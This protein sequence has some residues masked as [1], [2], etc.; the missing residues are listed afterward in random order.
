MQVIMKVIIHAIMK[1][2]MH[3]IMPVIMDLIKQVIQ[4]TISMIMQVSM[5]ILILC[6]K[7]QLDSLVAFISFIDYRIIPNIQYFF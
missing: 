4:V 3:H 1:V 2:I 6:T 7:I 5:Y